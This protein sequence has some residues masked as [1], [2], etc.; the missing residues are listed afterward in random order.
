MV[1]DGDR[2]L[3]ALA[4]IT[5]TEDGPSPAELVRRIRGQDVQVL[6]LLTGVGALRELG[7]LPPL[8]QGAVGIV[9]LVGDPL[10]PVPPARGWHIHVLDPTRPVEE[11]WA[12]A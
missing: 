6:H 10:E 12:H 2:A 3:M 11:A 9:S 1:T 7:Q 5:R 4:T 8:G